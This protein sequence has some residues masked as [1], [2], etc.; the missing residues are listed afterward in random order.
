MPHRHKLWLKLFGLQFVDKCLA[1]H[2]LQNFSIAHLTAFHKPQL[3]YHVCPSSEYLVLHLFHHHPLQR[4]SND[5][6]T[7]LKKMQDL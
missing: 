2:S 3:K 4:A 6:L 1:N 5:H 7:W